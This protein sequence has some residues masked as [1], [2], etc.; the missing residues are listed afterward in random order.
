MMKYV[1]LCV[2]LR[3]SALAKDGLFQ[4]RAF[5]QQV[6]T[7]IVC[8]PQFLAFHEMTD[9]FLGFRPVAQKC[10]RKVF[11]SGRTTYGRSPESIYR[12]GR[13]N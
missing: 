4:Y 5:T 6:S 1:D 2:K 10:H 13:R 8:S 9:V 7:F 11:E 12:E 3:N